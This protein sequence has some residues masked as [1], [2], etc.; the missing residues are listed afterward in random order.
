MIAGGGGFGC[1]HSLA[2]SENR[3]LFGWGSNDSN[4]LGINNSL[5]NNFSTPMNV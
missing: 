4:Q 1:S 3:N 2:V 5:S